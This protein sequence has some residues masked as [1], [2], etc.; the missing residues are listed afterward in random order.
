MIRKSSHI[1]RVGKRNQVTIPAAML[2]SLGVA[3]G[4]RVEVSGDDGVL[5]LRKAED[6]VDRA[7]GLLRQAGAPPRPIEDLEAVIAEAKAERSARAYERD[8]ATMS[9][10]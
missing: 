8:R 3:P 4:D 1:T 2:R 7:Y 6:P 5:E 10:A 9:G